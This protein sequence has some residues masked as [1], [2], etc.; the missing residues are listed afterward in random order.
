V[1]G[2]ALFYCGEASFQMLWARTD[3]KLV[4]FELSLWEGEGFVSPL[5]KTQ[6]HGNPSLKLDSPS[7]YQEH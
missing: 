2:L 1:T 3:K 7:V 6:Q 5:Y 4:R